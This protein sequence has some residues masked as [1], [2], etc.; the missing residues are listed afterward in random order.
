MQQDTHTSA[1][2]Q[3]LHDVARAIAGISDLPRLLDEIIA[4]CQQ[5]LAFEYCALALLNDNG[6]TY[7]LYTPAGAAIATR[8]LDHGIAGAVLGGGQ[9]HLV[10]GSRIAA[11]QRRIGSALLFSR[12]KPLRYHRDRSGWAR[13]LHESCR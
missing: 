11:Y 2:R 4:I 7:D 12:A 6:Q 1:E 13:L 10:T 8:P 3:V 5:G 9:M